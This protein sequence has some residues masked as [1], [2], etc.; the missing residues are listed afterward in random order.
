MPTAKRVDTDFGA[1]SRV[2]LVDQDAAFDRRLAR[3][4]GEAP[5][6]F[7]LS[8]QARDFVAAR[9][10]VAAEKPDLVVADAETNSVEAIRF[11]R[12]LISATPECRILAVTRCCDPSFAEQVLSA[13]ARGLLLKKEPAEEILFALQAVI[14]GQLYLNQSLALPL[15][16][17][18][19]SEPADIIV[20][21]E[22]G[23]LTNREFQVLELLGLGL[24]TREIAARLGIGRRTVA[25]HRT[26]I[27]HR[28][29]LRSATA[30]AQCSITGA[31]SSM[32]GD[33]PDS[34]LNVDLEY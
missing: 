2:L 31:Q 27:Q 20:P 9:A 28:L 1:Q 15:L 30:L 26:K 5:C 16:K 23:N 29:G 3:I 21:G 32:R 22:V 25:S 14:S 34:N 10:R 17:R 19:L 24:S 12:G 7:H 4:L 6:G 13:G 18:L 11:F 33:L 8:G